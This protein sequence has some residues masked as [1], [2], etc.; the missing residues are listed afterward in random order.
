MALLS[1]D[2]A[3]QGLYALSPIAIAVQG[4][5]DYIADGGTTHRPKSTNT[6][7]L[8][9]IKEGRVYATHTRA[10]TRAHQARAV[11]QVPL[12]PIPLHIPGRVTCASTRKTCRAHQLKAKAG[13]SS[14]TTCSRST[15]QARTLSASA[16]AGSYAQG[17]CAYSTSENLRSCGQASTESS[18]TTSFSAYNTLQ[19]RGVRNL[20]PVEIVAVVRAAVDRRP[21]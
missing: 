21:R 1:L 5:I 14:H 16:S 2:V 4:L 12:P 8:K 3:L 18:S 6:L 17:S 20:S 7:K 9:R 11:G 13:A 19:S 10:I 15:F